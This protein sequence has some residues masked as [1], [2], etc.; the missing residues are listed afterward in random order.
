[1][2]R[3][4]T[5]ALLAAL[6]AAGPASAECANSTVTDVDVAI[7]GGGAAGVYAATRLLDHNKTVAVFEKETLLGGQTETYYDPE[8]GAP[9]NVGVKVFTNTS[10]VDSF[11]RRFDF[12]TGSLNVGKQL[13]IGTK[14][15][16]F[17]TGQLLPNFTT[18]D[19]ATQAA[20]LQRYAAQLAKYP[21]LKFG[22]NL[23]TPVPEDL[24]LPFGEFMKKYEL[25]ALADTL[26]DFNGGF[27]PLLEV[28][29]LYILKY[30]DTYELQALQQGF[31][32]ASNGDTSTLYK[33]AARFLGA[34]VLYGVEDMHIERPAAAGGAITISVG[35]STTGARTVRARKLVMAIPPTLGSL[36]AAGLDVGADE[37]ALFG[38]L[39][40]GVWYSLVVAD[41]GVDMATTL[42]NRD[43]ARP[44]AYPAGPVVYSVVPQASTR[45]LYQVTVAA[46]Q[47]L[48]AGAV[49]ALVAADLA[50]LP[51]AVRA[52][53]ATAARP[54]VV[55]QAAHTWNVR[56]SV[57]DIKNGIYTRL[58]ALQ[59]QKDTW[60]IGAA[61]ATMSST[62]IWEGLEQEWLPKLLSTF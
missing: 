50:R 51:A 46:A 1:M 3:L 41:A 20:G 59:G 8:T 11:L 48:A 28:P 55:Y 60:Y 53:N 29:T 25:E 17:A 2:N 30:L 22:Y 45:R 19:A 7:I 61:W 9:V 35:N 58:E 37:A 34:R 15:V 38:A 4:L 16:N 13:G 14:F 21:Y 40:S 44:Y 5:S 33:S 24:T 6:A 56:A 42:R 31:I 54:R 18:P 10:V 49:D 12:P 26:F 43:P 36:R 32:I 47:P 52:A 23:P 62:T 39:T 27:V 57:E